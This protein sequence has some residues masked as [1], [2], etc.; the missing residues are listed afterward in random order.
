MTGSLSNM[1]AFVNQKPSVVKNAID[2]KQ[3]TN[4]DAEDIANKIWNKTVKIDPNFWFNKDIKSDQADFNKQLVQQKIITQDESQYVSW[5]SL[6]INKAGWF[7]NQGAFTVSKDG[8]TA[9]GHMTVDATGGET[10][11]QIAAKIAKANV[12]FNYNYWNQKAVGSYLS[13][14]QAILAN[15][16]ILTKAEAA[17][18]NGLQSPV[19]ITKAGTVVVNLN[20][21]NNQTSSV[22]STHVN[23]VNDGGDADQVMSSINN[24]IDLK[25]NTVGS[26]ADNV[27]IE[28][29]ALSY[30]NNVWSGSN[31]QNVT[32]THQLLAAGNNNVP[33]TILKDGQTSTRTLSLY[34]EKYPTMGRLFGNNTDLRLVVNLTSDATTALRTFFK[35]QTSPDKDS[36]SNAYFFNMIDDGNWSNSGFPKCDN[37]GFPP[38]QTIDAYMWTFGALGISNAEMIYQAAYNSPGFY[39]ALNTYLASGVTNGTMLFDLHFEYDPSYVYYVQ[40]YSFW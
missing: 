28:K 24:G 14:V 5:A 36:I 18:V 11:A 19:T 40:N 9:T 39:N 6:N 30:I 26:Y 17:D 22:A 37:F 2:S 33:V 21:N 29:D 35:N 34:S 3:A 15:E 13:Q 4:E 31:I 12:R 38:S 20:V 32:L 25:S 16:K 7:A 1:T 27:A 8:A 23:V 10:T